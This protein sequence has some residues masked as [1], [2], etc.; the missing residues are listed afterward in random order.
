MILCAGLV[1]VFL[2]VCEV[3]TE[4][5]RLYVC[6]LSPQD[7]LTLWLDFVAQNQISSQS[8][9]QEEDPQHHE[10]HVEL[11]ILHIQQLQ[12]LLWL[13][14]LTHQARTLQ[15]RPVHP[16]DR[17]YHPLKAVPESRHFWQNLMNPGSI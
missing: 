6:L 10:V 12:D 13:L 15:L 16:I 7:V 8:E 5:E 4:K 17:E 14:E 1:Y 3:E 11:R 9:D 2:H